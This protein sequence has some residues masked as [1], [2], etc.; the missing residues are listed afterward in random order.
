MCL[1]EL[2]RRTLAYLQDG[3]GRSLSPEQNSPKSV[4]MR[5]GTTLTSQPGLEAQAGGPVSMAH[6]GRAISC[7]FHWA[8]G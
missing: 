7:E 4:G 1:E 2:N 3:Q 8:P 5:C 6:A